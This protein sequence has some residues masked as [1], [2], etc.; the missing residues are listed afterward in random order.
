[1][2]RTKTTVYLEPEVLRATRIRAARTGKRDSQ[3]VEDALRQFLGLSVVD[4]IRAKADLDEG[5]ALNLAY[6]E[7]HALRRKRRK[8]P[9]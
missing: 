4:K 3:I 6:D 1:M 8:A 5:A 9:K 2:A 7:L